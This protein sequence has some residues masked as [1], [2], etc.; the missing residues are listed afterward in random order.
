MNKSERKLALLELEA[1]RAFFIGEWLKAKDIGDE[2]EM[3]VNH[4]LGVLTKLRIAELQ[5]HY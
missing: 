2:R 5:V 1:D 4:I 3:M